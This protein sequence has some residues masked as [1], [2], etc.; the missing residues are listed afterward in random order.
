MGPAGLQSAARAIAPAQSN[1]RGPE[2]PHWPAAIVRRADGR[3]LRRASVGRQQEIARLAAR[4][5]SFLI[6]ICWIQH[7]VGKNC[8]LVKGRN[9]AISR[10][11]SHSTAKSNTSSLEN[12]MKNWAL[13]AASPPLRL[14][15]DTCR[16]A[17]Q[18]GVQQRSARRLAPTALF[19]SFDDNSTT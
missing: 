14:A 11:P 16:G 9:P 1:K 17:P 19:F 15:R 18:R 5:P 13:G 6:S 3:C 2:Q 8:R 12:R 10:A 7:G 4:G